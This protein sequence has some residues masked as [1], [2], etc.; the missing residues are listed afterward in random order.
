MPLYR[1]LA[2]EAFGTFAL[3]F[4]GCA[5]VVMSAYPGS[6]WGVFGIAVAHA[7]VLS[8]AISATMAVSGGHLNPAVTIA[9]AA[10]RRVPPARAAAYVAVQLAA[11]VAAALA[12]KALVP[13]GG[14][15]MF[16]T[17]GLSGTLTITH[18]IAIEALL[19]FFLM[20]AV[21]GTCIVPGA[22]RIA[23]FGI[24]LTLLFAIMAGGSLTGGALNPA[25]AFG[26]AVASGQWTA[27]I[28]WWV[29][30][31]AGALLAA[32]LWEY[33]IMPKPGEQDA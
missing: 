24:G 22:P 4:F 17:P 31:I 7:V 33:V 16:G 30:P 19:T 28:V 2:A 10:M 9:L 6:D 26:P 1:R 15:V 5:S 20:S 14:S 18:G 11:S 3:V 21:Y 32:A 29:G 27:H 23:G 25:R 13:T 8:V 12:L